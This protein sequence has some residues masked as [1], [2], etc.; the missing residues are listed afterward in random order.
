MSG[1]NIMNRVIRV[2][3]NFVH[4]TEKAYLVFDDSLK[5]EVWYPKSQISNILRRK[6]RIFFDCPE[7][8]RIKKLPVAEDYFEEK[9]KKEIE[10]GLRPFFDVY[11]KTSKKYSK[12]YFDG[13]WAEDE[14]W[15][16]DADDIFG[17]FF[18][19]C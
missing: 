6:E 4:E 2:R 17:T 19:Q 1:K 3:G 11:P 15:D 12:P 9:K 7:W 8:L 10:K 16:D 18:D 13:M 14:Y 5:T